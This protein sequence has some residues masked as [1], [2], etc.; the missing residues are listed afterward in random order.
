MVNSY[1]KE[2]HSLS[3]FLLT[4]LFKLLAL[5]HKSLVIRIS[6]YFAQL[7]LYLWNLSFFLEY[8]LYGILVIF[9]CPSLH[10][11]LKNLSAW[12]RDLCWFA[13]IVLKFF[14]GLI[15]ADNVNYHGEREHLCCDLKS[16]AMEAI[17][18]ILK[19][20]IRKTSTPANWFVD[21]NRNVSLSVHC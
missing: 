7:S 21:V 16:R 4:T 17:R 10:Y 18:K 8:S 15:G 14:L 5:T 3:S 20:S 2:P 6:L 9:F 13:L 19:E 11:P 12:E 1:V